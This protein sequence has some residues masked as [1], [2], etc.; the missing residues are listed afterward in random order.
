MAALC[1]VLYYDDTSIKI[2]DCQPSLAEKRKGIRTSG[3]VADLGTEKIARLNPGN[4]EALDVLDVFY[5]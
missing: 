4:L 5:E 3:L 2:I 1:S